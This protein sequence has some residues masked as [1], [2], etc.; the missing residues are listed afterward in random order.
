M[1]NELPAETRAAMLKPGMYRHYKGGMY[2]VFGVARHSSND[3]QGEE[4]MVVY[5][6]VTKQCLWVR[7]LREFT[8]T[9]EVGGEQVPRFTW[10]A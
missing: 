3:K 5:W 1:D 7:E 8:A 6:S 10:V 4:P 2:I 9:V